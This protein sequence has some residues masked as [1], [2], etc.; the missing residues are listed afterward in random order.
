MVSRAE[1]RT[2]A[3]PSGS[4][5]A[6]AVLHRIVWWNCFA[7]GEPASWRFFDR[8]DRNRLRP[9]SARGLC[10][11]LSLFP[12][13]DA[14]SNAWIGGVACVNRDVWLHVRSLTIS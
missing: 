13:C 8:F 9:L 11:A 5:Y 3:R 12:V 1:R 10:L 2:D 4:G 14:A 7:F 6:N